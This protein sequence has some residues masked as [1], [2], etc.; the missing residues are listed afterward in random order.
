MSQ[1]YTSDVVKR[2][3][4]DD[5][6]H[7][8]SLLSIDEKKYAKKKREM[9]I[10]H[11]KCGHEYSLDIYEF[12]HGSR[13]CGKC[14][15][16]GLRKHF[17]F[18]LEEVI[19][20]VERLTQGEYSFL[21]DMY[22]NGNTKYR[23]QHNTCGTV[24]KKTLSKFKSG[25]RCPVCLKRGMDSMTYHYV[26]DIFDFYNIEYSREHKYDACI[27]PETN[28]QL[29]YD[30]YLPD[31]NTLIEI[32]GE[33]HER[34]SFGGVESFE[35][36]K[37]RDKIKDKFAAQNNIRLI[38]IA[39][40]DWENLPE[41]IAPVISEILKDK[42][43]AES[44]RNIKQKRIPERINADLKKVHNGE[45]ILVD[46][47]YTGV[48]RQH[49]FKHLLCG[50]QFVSTLY[51]IKSHSCPCPSCR[52]KIKAER[53]FEKSDRLLY[54][55]TQGKYSLVADDMHYRDNKRLTKC[56]DC[57]YVWYVNI[58]NILSNN[59]GCPR[60]KQIKLIKDWR[61]RYYNLVNL[62]ADNMRIS[63]N[64]K[65]WIRYNKKQYKCRKLEPYKVRMLQRSGYPQLEVK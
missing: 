22:I 40:K 6:G 8:Y 30:Y 45:Y 31:I 59:G 39:A 61:E 18:S 33:Q 42:V 11:N 9:T 10:K 37:R 5:T 54:E 29:K 36:T 27:N 44:I 1:K 32:D 13:R 15:G 60:C 3:V 43:S 53:S 26:K 4:E 21:E 25:Q 34:P 35:K 65:Q 63:E 2:I 58:G 56:N 23:F 51:Q 17:A 38:R 55:R 28:A 16:K 57:K 19:A 20:D 48:D 50:R 14:K 7:E 41:I 12:I 49:N 64:L 62:L 46:N 52:E 24:F 47:F